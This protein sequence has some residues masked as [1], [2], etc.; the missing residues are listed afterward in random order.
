MEIQDTTA[1]E[2]LQELLA[3]ACVLSPPVRWL[4]ELVRRCR[5]GYVF[6]SK[7]RDQSG[8]PLRYTITPEVLAANV[9]GFLG[10]SPRHDGP[11]LEP[12]IEEALKNE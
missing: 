9:A 5:E 11:G 3:A 12:I 10:K 1:L 7:R 8:E 6:V 2:T 4:E